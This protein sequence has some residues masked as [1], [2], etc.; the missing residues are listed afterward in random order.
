MGVTILNDGDDFEKHYWNAFISSDFPSYESYWAKY[1]VPLTNRP[2]N[3]HFKESSC[4]ISAGYSADD[5]C[6]AQLHYTTFRHLVRAYEIVYFLSTKIQSYL[7]TDILAEGLFH[8]TAAQ[9]VAF[10]FLQRVAEPNQFDPW[11]TKKS[12][13]LIKSQASKEALDKWKLINNYPLQDI[14]DYRNHLTHG[15]MSP[16]IHL[17]PKILIP[18]IGFETAYLDWRLVTD[19][20]SKNLTSIIADFDSLDVILTD[21]WKRTLHY[22]ESE[23]QKII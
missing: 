15:R 20:N 23:W 11:A 21:A 3:V 10:E 14:R 12:K 18:K 4:L 6:K 7:D 8:V 5:V 22:L 2:L 17:K 9:D 1:I 19:W 13:S 16:N